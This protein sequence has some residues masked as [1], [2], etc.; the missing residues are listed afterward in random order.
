MGVGLYISRKLAERMGGTISVEWSEVGAGTRFSLTLPGAPHTHAYKETAST[1]TNPLRSVHEDEPL[2][3][4]AQHEYTILIVDD[5]ASNIHILRNILKRHS[6]NV[7]T[8][9]SANEAMAKLKDYPHVD[10]AIVDVM[11][12]R[13]SGIE[14]CR[15]LRSSIRFLTFR[16]CLR[17]SRI[18][19]M[20]LHLVLGRGPMIT[21][22]SHLMRRHSSLEFK[23]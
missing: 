16:F 13:I 5:E 3:S 12:P 19:R 20:I 23:R 7:I 11:M 15:M 18:L 17:Q 6:Y 10:L 21:S 9:F 14:L 1:L 4:V 22:P 8:A 2:D